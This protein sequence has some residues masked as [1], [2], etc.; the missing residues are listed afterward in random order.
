MTMYYLT[1]NGTM[2]MLNRIEDQNWRGFKS[3]P[4]YEQRAKQNERPE[5][6]TRMDVAANE[7][8]TQ[9]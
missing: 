6:K 1:G 8:Q 4:N 3:K 7:I 2:N 9:L 5:W